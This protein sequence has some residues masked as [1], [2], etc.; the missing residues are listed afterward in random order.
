MAGVLLLLVN[1]VVL[2][3]EQA[4]SSASQ[5]DPLV[6]EGRDLFTRVWTVSDGLGPLINARSCAGCHAVPAVGGLGTD[7]RSFVI[8]TPPAS[9]PSGGHVFRRLRVSET[10]AVTEQAVPTVRTIRKS[11]SLFGSGLLEEVSEAEIVAAASGASRPGRLPE[12][13]FGWKGR[14]RNIEEA[15]AAAFVNELGLSSSR[16]A[17][18][19]LD[20]SV[21]H[22]MPEISEHQLAAVAA[23]IRS[24]PPPLSGGQ[25]STANRGRELFQRVECATCHTPTFPSLE[26]LNVFPY[27]DLRLHDM[28]LGLADGVTEGTAGGTEFKT[29][30]LWGLTR[31]GPPYLHDG[32]AQTIHDAILAH[33]GDAR[34]AANSYRELV[35][36]D[37][38]VLLTFLQSL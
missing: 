16:F 29:P 25:S 24:L 33:D 12:G 10:G 2:G 27:T 34:E 13:R 3:F 38:Q 15:V 21:A 31:S 5:I 9:D 32:R 11:P 4:R 18:A 37:R 17:D 26:K 7:E 14:L 35:P 6:A 36:D 30:P 20:R 1:C 23:F 19:S 8:M 22:H 28:G